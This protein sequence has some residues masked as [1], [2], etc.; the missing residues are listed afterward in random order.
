MLV[1]ETAMA[2]LELPLEYSYRRETADFKIIGGVRDNLEFV[3][4]G[5]P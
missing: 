4:F 5:P 2:D 1:I 3:P